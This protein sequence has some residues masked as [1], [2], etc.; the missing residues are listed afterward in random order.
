[1]KK[2]IIIFAIIAVVC[3]TCCG[4]TAKDP[5]VHLTLTL[6]GQKVFEQQYNLSF[7]TKATKIFIY[8]NDYD[9]YFD[10]FD[11]TESALIAIDPNLPAEIDRL[12]EE[13]YIAPQNATCVFYNGSFEYSKEVYGRKISKQELARRILE[14]FGKNILIDLAT[15]PI[16]P[17]ISEVDLKMNTVK[18]SEFSTSFTTSSEGR[19]ANIAVATDA[20]NN[21]II[22]AGDSFSF[23]TVVGAR[24]KAN[25][26][27]SATII[28]NGEF[29]EGIGGGVCQVSTTLYNAALLAGASVS[30]V[31]HHS[32]PISYVAPSFDAMVSEFSD[33]VFENNTNYP[34]YISA[35]AEDKT[36]TFTIFGYP[37]Y[38]DCSPILRSVVIETISSTA[39]TDIINNSELADDEDIKILKYPIDG[40]ISEG[41][42]DL[43]KNGEL[44]SSTRLRRDTYKPQNGKRI[45]REQSED[46]PIEN[47]GLATDEAS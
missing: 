24:T 18:L 23:N 21:T 20:I 14:Q 25:G 1:M 31:S 6:D 36:L 37:K 2:S 27:S 10:H 32:L 11:S 22:E 16:T 8:S 5:D 12:A 3:L 35:T 13:Y 17:D 41:Y 39:Y 38:G 34:I 46:T 44:V 43:Y 47:D 40:L 33:L 42:I 7:A 9:R 4:F 19:S 26:Y 30:T 45:L 15:T 29:I 28:E